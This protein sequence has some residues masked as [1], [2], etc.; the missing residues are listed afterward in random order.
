MSYFH[1]RFS[2]AYSG[3]DAMVVKETWLLSGKA[4]VSDDKQS[5]TVRTSPGGQGGEAGLTRAVRA[6]LPT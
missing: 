1:K 5:Q 2:S 4:S 6:G 3:V